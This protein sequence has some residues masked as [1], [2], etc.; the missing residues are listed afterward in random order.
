MPL[1][2]AVKAGGVR[3]T[4]SKKKPSDKKDKVAAPAQENLLNGETKNPAQD[5]AEKMHET[6]KAELVA[7]KMHMKSPSKKS[8][9]PATYNPTPKPT[10][11]MGS[12]AVNAKARMIQQP[13]KHN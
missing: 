7:A 4:Q 3:V 1:T 2:K 11:F 13:R 8:K 5:L 6:K 12:K 10:A 9:F